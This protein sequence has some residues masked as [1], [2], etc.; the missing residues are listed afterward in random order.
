M[1]ISFGCSSSH[2]VHIKTRSD[3]EDSHADLSS[4]IS[5]CFVLVNLHIRISKFEFLNVNNNCI[6]LIQVLLKQV[7]LSC[8]IKRPTLFPEP[9]LLVRVEE[10]VHQVIA[11][12]FRDLKRLL[13]NTLIQTLRKINNRIGSSR[14]DKDY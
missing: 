12:I 8:S 4:L 6:C 3:Y 1:F 14:K 7:G 10:C 9:P 11:V 2:E 13:L 5:L